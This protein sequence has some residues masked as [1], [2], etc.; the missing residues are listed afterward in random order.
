[1][2]G[3]QSKGCW[4]NDQ[5]LIHNVTET[6]IKEAGACLKDAGSGVLFELVT[7]KDKQRSDDNEGKLLERFLRESS[8]CS[9]FKTNMVKKF[10]RLE[11]T[12]AITSYFIM[13]YISEIFYYAVLNNS[14]DEALSISSS[15]VST[16]NFLSAIS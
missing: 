9:A 1:M 16:Q 14:S 13:F 10:E 7:K 6:Q 3:Y 8:H 2:T 12:E 11:E 15:F 4:S 5:N